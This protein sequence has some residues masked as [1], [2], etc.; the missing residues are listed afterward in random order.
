MVLAGS[1]TQNWAM[2][3]QPFPPPTSKKLPDDRPAQ[4]GPSARARI[5]QGA[6]MIIV[7][8][9]TLLLLAGI[10]A[11]TLG[12]GLSS[13]QNTAD[14]AATLQAQF[15]AESQMAVV[16]RRL[17]DYQIM[18]SPSRP[19]PNNTTITNINVSPSTTKAELQT[20]AEQFCNYNSSSNTWNTINE[21]NT[22]RSIDDPD[23]FIGAQQCKVNA[24]IVGA[25][26]FEVLADII[27]PE[28][29]DILAISSERPSDVNNSDIV[30]DW[31]TSLLTTEKGDTNWKINIRALRVVKL[32]PA[33]YR[34]YFGVQNVK[35]R[36]QVSAAQRVLTGVRAQDGEWWIDIQLPNLLEDVL[37]T[38]HHRA[39]PPSGT[40]YTPNG[41]PGIN[42]TDQ[43]FDGSIHTNEKF[44]FDGSSSA[45]FVGKV[46]SV[47]CIDLPENGRPDS[48]D[49]EK[50]AGVYIRGSGLNS[51]PD[52][53]ITD[54]ERD[55]AIADRVVEF[56]RTVNF[57]KNSQ[58]LSKIDYAKT[59]FTAAYKPLPE[60]END[61]VEAAQQGGLYFG[62]SVD[63]MTM[64]AADGNGNALTAYSNNKWTEAAGDIYQYISLTRKEV[65]TTRNCVTGTW[66]IADKKSG[67]IYKPTAAYNNQPQNIEGNL[68]KKTQVVSGKTRYYIRSVVCNSIDSTTTINEEYRYGSDM[69]L[70]KKPASGPWSNAVTVRNN[71]NGVIY[72]PNFSDVTGPS[73]IGGDTTGAINKAPPALASFAK[74][75]LAASGNVKIS[76]DLTLSETPCSFSEVKGTPPCTRKPANILGVYSQDGNVTFGAGAPRNLNIHAAIIASSGEVTVE[77]YNTRPQNGNIKII[78]SLIENWYG[79]FGTYGNGSGTGYG[80]DFTY[81]NRLA[82]G[83]TPPFFP[84]SPRWDVKTAADVSKNRLFNIIPS[85]V[86]SG[87]F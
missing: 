33:R 16:K 11:A 46:S 10:L 50:T 69:I 52:S 2:P 76:S 77:D 61:Q 39:K 15:A 70:K 25:D 5:T 44:L 55:T 82:T 32:T 23:I 38:N 72:S 41:D 14:Q 28:A 40:A 60:N 58:D 35:A 48:G 78:G 68:A 75:T 71:F 4:S 51:A 84:V 47:G 85:N 34:F 86:K 6:T 49:C 42:F 83:I 62:G 64:K 1:E 73:R 29:Y 81:D 18:L 43:R 12:L 56:P 36:G 45:T 26:Q 63:S 19:G 3:L 54:I 17:Y 59:D 24:N 9:F 87:S 13:R 74:I 66:V 79:A 67:K 20:Y 80:R 31:W 7:V 27:T 22:A 53:A 21:F 30:E 8:L 57:I 37:M 65:S